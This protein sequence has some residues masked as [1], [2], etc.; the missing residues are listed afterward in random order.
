MTSI[1]KNVFSNEELDY[2]NNHPEVL[3]AKSS[4][5]SKLSGKI[6]FSVPITNSIR[7]TL[8]S[9]F[10]LD[11]SQTSQI[12]MRWI[13]GDTAP[14]MDIGSSNFKNTYYYTS[15]THLVNLS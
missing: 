14:H 12:P 15:T 11:L 6:Y 5:D 2:L 4:L 3:L 13:K 7:D 10:G 8:Q 1:Y 9:Q